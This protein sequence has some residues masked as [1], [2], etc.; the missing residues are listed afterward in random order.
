MIWD[1][2]TGKPVYNAVVW[3]DTRTDEIINELAKKG[4]QER[5]RDKT[6]LP[7][8][9]YFSGPKIKWILDHVEG[10]RQK[11]ER[12]ELLFGN[13]DTWIIWN[14][15][16]EHVT[17]VTNASRTMLMDLKTLNWD[18]EI[19]SLLGIPGACYLKFAHRLKDME[20]HGIF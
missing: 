16:G 2:K 20:L 14:L 3:Q 10:S 5:F 7:L 13:I 1:R 15:T 8:A 9:T 19:L 17:D 4:G 18:E 12:G 6:G 11:A